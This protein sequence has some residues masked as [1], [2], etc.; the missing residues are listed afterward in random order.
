[1]GGGHI[2]IG[3]I[4]N[5][6]LYNNNLASLIENAIGGS[7]NDTIVGNATNNRF[8]GGAGN[9]TL[10]GVSGTSDVAVYLGSST[11]YQV[12]QNSDG[13]WTVADL[14]SG[15]PDGADTLRNIEFLQFSD[16]MVAVGPIQPVTIIESNGST[17][18]T[19]VGNHFYLYNN[20]GSGPSLKYSGS[21]FVAGQF[22]A[23]APISAEQTA[24]GYE[25]AWRLPGADQYTIWTTD[26][27][28]NYISNASILSGTSATVESA[29][30]RFH[31]DL[32]GDGVIGSPPLPTTIIESNGSTSLTEVGGHFYL[33]NNAGSGP[34]LKYSGS[35]FMAGQ[36]GAWAPIG[37]EQTASG[38]EVAWRLPGADQYTI[39][40][41]DS[42][43][44]YISNAS[45]LSGTSATVESAETRFHQDLNS[46][47]VIGPSA[48]PVPVN[49]ASDPILNNSLI[50]NMSA[51]VQI[52][53]DTFVFSDSVKKADIANF[54]ESNDLVPLA[55]ALLANL[56]DMPALSVDAESHLTVTID[57][58]HPVLLTELN[59]HFFHI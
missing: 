47:G 37:A 50:E 7:G 48:G 39:W 11:S 19:E 30:T 26:S 58:S 17:S 2:A 28:G 35:D 24:S 3:N 10:D 20:A 40:T 53:D 59:S 4:A 12:T 21:D 41:T 36:F 49:I 6:Y 32:N 44:N 34:S 57:A 51:Q 27:N 15:N 56:D 13:S 33:Y 23:W 16:R 25:V 29:E 1:L 45:I 14:R 46:D 18:L 31:Q 22:G 52:G 42:N 5:G 38:Y 9:D 55:N 54:Q 43:G 8:T